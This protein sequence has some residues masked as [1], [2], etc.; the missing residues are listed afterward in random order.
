[1][2]IEG[3]RI[4]V[5]GGSSGL[6][7]A[8]VRV[9]VREGA[10][11]AALDV[12]DEAGGSVVSAA[13]EEGPGRAFYHHCDVRH[14]HGVLSSFERAAQDLGGIDALVHFAGVDATAAAESMTE[15]QW[16]FV[17]DVNLKGTFLANQAV[18]PYLR[19]GGGSIVNVT[20]PVAFV[21][22]PDRCHYAASKGGV[23]SLSRSLA[24]EWGPHGITVVAISPVAQTAMTESARERLSDEERVVFDA[25]LRSGPLGR[26][27]DAE[28]DIAP[29]LVF[30][31]SDASRFITAQ[32][33][34]VDGG[35]L[36]VR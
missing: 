7:Q 20:S 12:Q 8:A 6:G 30:L 13:N 19:D 16:D 5:T 25:G 32:I 23:A 27:G 33:L 24:A 14:K 28:T 31:V 2:Q 17:V 9:F 15:E 34:A 35:I 10:L 36:P 1:L 22:S 21:A 26:V 29:V 18:F 11:V 4:V 3:K